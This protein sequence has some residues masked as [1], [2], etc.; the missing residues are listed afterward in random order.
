MKTTLKLTLVLFFALFVACNSNDDIIENSNDIFIEVNGDL[1]TPSNTSSGTYNVELSR[2]FFDETSNEP[3]GVQFVMDIYD[4]ERLYIGGLGN[5]SSCVEVELFVDY[6]SDGFPDSS[7]EVSTIFNAN[8]IPKEEKSGKCEIFIRLKDIN[9]N[10]I[11]AGTAIPDQITQYT[12]VPGV[13]GYSSFT[14]QNLTFQTND[15]TGNQ[16]TVGGRIV[17]E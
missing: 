7:A 10:I 14:F 8:S 16:F 6:F 17:V 9:D 11:I 5:Y 12:L 4:P 2:F 1:R 15:N 3:L 13:G